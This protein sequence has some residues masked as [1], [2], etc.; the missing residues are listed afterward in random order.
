[1]R[2]SVSTA[3]SAVAREAASPCVASFGDAIA[4][5]FVRSDRISSSISLVSPSS[6][7]SAGGACEAGRSSRAPE[8]R[9]PSARR[10]AAP[11][12]GGSRRR[13]RRCRRGVTANPT[14]LRA[15]R[16]HGRHD[17]AFA[18]ADDPDLFVGNLRA[19]REEED[20]CLGVVGEVARG[21]RDRTCRWIR[22]RRGRRHARLRFRGARDGRRGRGT[23]CGRAAP[24]RGS[25]APSRSRGPP[26]GM[27]QC[28]R[29]KSTF[30][31]ASPAFVSSFAA[32]AR[33]L[34]R[35]GFPGSWLNATATS[36]YGKGGLASAGGR[37]RRP[38]PHVE[39]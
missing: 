1:M 20:A 7:A 17:P 18:V 27:G 25:A 37:A 23:A 33:K 31:S 32:L 4:R 24:R 6:R 28:R 9:P 15:R 14:S 35:V 3:A 5:I 38:S 11:G 36:R 12:G 10:S 13:R 21:G 29:A 26:P 34:S 19:R 39:T 8:G 22:P 2:S 30:R 16:H